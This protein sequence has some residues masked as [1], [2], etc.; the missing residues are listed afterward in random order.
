MSYD[1]A[2]VL[3]TGGWDS[4]FLLL[5]L[6]IEKKKRVEPIYLIDPKRKSV[7]YEFLAMKTIKQKILSRYPEVK[8]MLLPTKYYAI[9]DFEIEPLIK[10]SCEVYKHKYKLGSQ[11]VWLASFCKTKNYTHVHLGVEKGGIFERIFNHEKDREDFNTIFKYFQFPLINLSKEDFLIDAE[12]NN[13]L[14][15]MKETWF[16]HKPKR[17]K[18]CGKCNPCKAVI[19][20]NMSWRI[21]KIQLFLRHF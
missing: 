2:K 4:T 13:W 15:I 19:K 21:P 9:D 7:R 14:D 18:P 20:E 1:T 12:K 17:K 5:K 8:N 6:L 16:C 11:Y 3:W 10:K